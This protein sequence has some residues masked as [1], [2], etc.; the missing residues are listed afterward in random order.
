M[1]ICC[2]A[3]GFYLPLRFTGLTLFPVCIYAE[4]YAAPKS[5]LISELERYLATSPQ[6]RPDHLVAV[7]VGRYK[8]LASR[9]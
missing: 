8:M 4:L 5:T 9:M 7:I 2:G 6:S 1:C 3:K